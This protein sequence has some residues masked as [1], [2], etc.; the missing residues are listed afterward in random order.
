MSVNEMPSHAHDT[1]FFNNMT[2]NGEMVSDFEGVFGKGMTAS[3]AKS[4]TGKSVIEMWWKE[5]TNNAEGN[6]YS[7]LTA[8]KG[9]SVAHNNMP[10]YLAVYMWKRTG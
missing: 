5:Q 1:P 3:A 10:P 8:S 9:G 2:N 4:L 6:E 7:Y